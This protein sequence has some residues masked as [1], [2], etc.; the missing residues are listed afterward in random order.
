[1]GRFSV[2]MWVKLVL[3]LF[4]PA[5]F[6]ALPGGHGP[7]ALVTAVTAG[8]AA[9]FVIA[10]VLYGRVEAAVPMHVRAISL[11]ERARLANFIRLRDPDARGRTRPRAPS[12]GSAAA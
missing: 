12:L 5:L 11:R 10:V 1:M 9:A 3:A 4:L 2:V 8:I 7:L 6:L